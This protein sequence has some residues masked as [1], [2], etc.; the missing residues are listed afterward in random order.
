MTRLASKLNQ[1]LHVHLPSNP[2]EDGLVH[3]FVSIP[4]ALSSAEIKEAFQSF[5]GGFEKATA[6]V[7]SGEAIIFEL[8]F[9]DEPMEK[10]FE[11]EKS[12]VDTYYANG[13]G[14]RVGMELRGV[15]T[16]QLFKELSDVGDVRIENIGLVD[17]AEQVQGSILSSREAGYLEQLID[18]GFF[19]LPRR[20]ITL[21]GAAARLAV[22]DSYLSLEVRK[23]ADKVF[24]EYLRRAT[25]IEQP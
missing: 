1:G 3:G 9:H 15:S 24:R 17:R 8:R 20:G 11:L 19:E 5:N 25:R 21:E 18:W 14:E 2:L 7:T 22:S 16:S 10:L 13:E 4:Q 23:I 6:Y 12:T